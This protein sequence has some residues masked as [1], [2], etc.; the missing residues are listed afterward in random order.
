MKVLGLDYFVPQSTIDELL[1]PHLRQSQLLR[2]NI[3]GILSDFGATLGKPL[4]VPCCSTTK[5]YPGVYTI[6][7]FVVTC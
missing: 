7:A 4:V 3:I 2:K 6:L 1:N 5:G